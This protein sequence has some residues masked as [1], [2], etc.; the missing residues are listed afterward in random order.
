MESSYKVFSNIL[1]YKY[2]EYVI[3]IDGYFFNLDDMI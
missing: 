1:G 2:I 3:N